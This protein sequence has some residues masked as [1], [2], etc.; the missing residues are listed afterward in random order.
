MTSAPPVTIPTD[1]AV[2]ADPQLPQLETALNVG[3]MRDLGLLPFP[4]TVGER[5]VGESNIRVAYVRYKPA[6]NCIVLYESS[7]EIGPPLWAY[8]KLFADE[9]DFKASDPSQV[10]A[11][12]S[13]HRIAL[14]RFPLDLEMP[15]LSMAADPELAGELLAR[16]VRPS[17]RS[18]FVEQWGGWEP[19]R[20]KPE[21]RC[22]MR[23]VYRSPRWNAD[24]N[25]YARFYAPGEGVRTQEWHRYFS[26]MEASK[27]RVPRC[28]GYSAR[29]RVLLLRGE[30]G[31]ALQS[32][33]RE[34][35]NVLVEAVKTAAAALAHWHTLAPPPNAPAR[36]GAVEGIRRARL[37]VESLGGGSSSAGELA[38]ELEASVP[39]GGVRTLIHGDF[40]YDQIL[41]RHGVTKFLDLD[42]LA[43]GDPVEDIANFCAHVKLLAAQG[44]LDGSS[45]DWIC[46]QFVEAYEVAAERS[47]PVEI[48]RWHLS[49]CLFKLAVLPF[50]KFVPN[51]PNRV[52]A[53]LDLARGATGEAPC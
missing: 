11:Y 26:I 6:T 32:F 15:A 2:P 30:R 17:R 42:E 33:F 25:F 13:P 38:G 39:A 41:L 19:I 27:V 21:R 7:R 43:V 46:C 53:V 23:G 34:P 44:D 20:Y 49:A 4:V 14:M 50:R 3:R 8:A 45:S 1:P 51:W 5:S 9:R 36:E 52:E 12:D 35:Q 18:R 22:V 10:T 37:A 31:K 47:I 28:L 48:F 29:R 24:R 16:I 40:Y